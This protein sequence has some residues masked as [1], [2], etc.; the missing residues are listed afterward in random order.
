MGDA[1]AASTLSAMASADIHDVLMLLE[2]DHAA[3][4]AALLPTM[5]SGVLASIELSRGVVIADLM[6]EAQGVV[7]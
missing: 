4:I 3:R 2:Q 5:A 6:E 7:S 1:E